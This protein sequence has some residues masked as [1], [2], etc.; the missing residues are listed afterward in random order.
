MMRL[1]LGSEPSLRLKVPVCA[2]AVSGGK[3]RRRRLRG[4]AG[5]NQVEETLT[6]KAMD[7]SHWL[8]P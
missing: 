5:R 7:C 3:G 6:L 8:V 4:E 2:A 1:V